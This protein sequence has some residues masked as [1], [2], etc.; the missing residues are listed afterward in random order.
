MQELKGDRSNK[1]INNIN[2]SLGSIY[3][4]ASTDGGRV[5]V[6]VVNNKLM[7]IDLENNYSMLL[8]NQNVQTV[9]DGE[10]QECVVLYDVQSNGQ[11]GVGCVR[12]GKQTDNCKQ[13]EN[14]QRDG[15]KY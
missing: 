13:K 4:L 6:F 15:I 9:A 3:L 12:A 1:S 5:R 14:L 10:I 8:V 7:K 11:F 2:F